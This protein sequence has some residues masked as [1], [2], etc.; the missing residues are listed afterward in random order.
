VKKGIGDGNVC[1]DIDR[2]AQALTLT[3][4]A[5]VIDFVQDHL[6]AETRHPVR[7]GARRD[8]RR[9][10]PELVLPIKIRLRVCNP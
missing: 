3:G 8:G 4:F 5:I 1:A 7:L 10:V 9:S 6:H 2:L